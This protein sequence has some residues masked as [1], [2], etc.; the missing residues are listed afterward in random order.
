MSGVEGV[1][2][3]DLDDCEAGVGG[4]GILAFAFIDGRIAILKRRVR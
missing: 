2:R 1:E 4:F 3:E